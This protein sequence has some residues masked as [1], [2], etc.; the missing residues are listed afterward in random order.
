MAKS[1]RSKVKKRLRT[2]KRSVIKKQRLDPT[3]KLG[4][5]GA[6]AQQLLNEA[7]TGHIRPRAPAPHCCLAVH[8]MPTRAARPASPLQ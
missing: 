4:E 7:A 5:G 8:A 3:S 2:V 1:I 6:R